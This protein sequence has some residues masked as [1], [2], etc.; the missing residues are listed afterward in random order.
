M[1]V[2]VVEDNV[3]ALDA[4]SEY[5]RMFGLEVHCAQSAEAGLALC[6]SQRFDAVITDVHLPGISGAELA[7]E[8][9]KMA[10][11]PAMLVG[12]SGGEP[13]LALRSQFTHFFGK[14]VD[15]ER[16]RTLLLGEFD[17]SGRASKSPER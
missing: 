10:S 5:L 3:D 6:D 1:R 16:L 7:R 2:L 17:R 12:M 13:G 14:P 8:V 11:R 15:L 4:V 9:A